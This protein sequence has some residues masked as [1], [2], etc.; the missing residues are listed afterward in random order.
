MTAAA[1]SPR[2]PLEKAERIAQRIA[3]ELAPMCERIEV[4][5]SIRRRRPDCGDVDLVLLPKCRA[6]V[7]RIIERC[8]RHA[9]IQ[10]R[11]AQYVVFSLANGFQLDLWIAHC[12]E[13]A[14]PDLFETKL[15]TAP[16]NFGVLLLA[17]TGSAMFNVWIAQ[18]AKA[19]GLHFN[20]HRGIERSPGGRVVAAT[21]EAEIFAA[22]G[23]EFIQ[24]ERRER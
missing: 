15:E 3:A 11:G 23:L 14:A 8:G 21:E 1:E 2:L 20:P 9:A 10:K 16:G 4:A 18:T 13:V 22:L 17:R 5:G 7:D 19:R 12:G 6:H 24:P